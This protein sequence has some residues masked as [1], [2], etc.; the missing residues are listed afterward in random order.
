MGPLCKRAIH[1]R[2]PI[3]NNFLTPSIALPPS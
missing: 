1:G 2:L 3:K